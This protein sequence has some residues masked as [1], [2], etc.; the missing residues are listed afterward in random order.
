MLN[1]VDLRQQLMFKEEREVSSL[2]T[3]L[4]RCGRRRLIPFLL[5]SQLLDTTHIEFADRPGIQYTLSE[6]FSKLFIAEHALT[7]I[8]LPDNELTERE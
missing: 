5:P 1:H 7:D 3:C 4:F 2:S 8:L 6:V